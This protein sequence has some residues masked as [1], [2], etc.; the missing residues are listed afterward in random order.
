ML[1]PLWKKMLKINE[2]EHYSGIRGD[3]CLTE[4]NSPDN[5]DQL[6]GAFNENNNPEILKEELKLY[7]TL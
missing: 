7:A 5:A 6:M 3:A 1:L 2:F 4:I